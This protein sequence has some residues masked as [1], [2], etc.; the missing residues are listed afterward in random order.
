MSYQYL[1]FG[2]YNMTETKNN[3]LSGK[4]CLKMGPPLGIEIKCMDEV[5]YL[6]MHVSISVISH[7]DIHSFIAHLA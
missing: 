5:E 1:P 6:T 7:T 2:D 3:I 4:N